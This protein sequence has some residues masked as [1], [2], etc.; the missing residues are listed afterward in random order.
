MFHFISGLP[1]AG[2]T[3]TAAIL[4]QNP[5]F[6]AGMSSPVASLFDH[7]IAQ[8]SAGSELSTM[9]NE[10]QR[11]RLLRGLFD[12]YYADYAQPVIFDTNRA[13]TAQLPALM[14]LFPEAKIIC[15][16]RDVAWVMDSLERQYRNNAFEHTRLFNNAAE[17]ATVYTRVEALANANRLVGFAWHAL[18]EA[19]YSEYAERVL[20]LEYDLLTARP[21]EVF[22]LVYDFLGE[23][24]YPHDF[25]K[26]E[27]DAP[28]FDAQL[29]MDGLHRVRPQVKPQARPT[30][31]PP[32]LFKRY[33]QLAFWRDLKDSKAFRIVQQASAEKQSETMPEPEPAIAPEAAT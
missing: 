20:L 12:S 30:I 26:V 33:A 17:R 27:Y 32:D 18:R 16:V 6:H 13:W 25:A 28:E 10:A 7:L 15:C 5:R 21:G 2:S 22:K 23:P 29:G 9:V 11:A 1:R 19:C 3:L 8:V 14:R 24:P 31:L 4:R